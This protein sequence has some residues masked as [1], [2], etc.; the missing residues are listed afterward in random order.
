[1]FRNLAL[2]VLIVFTMSLT[3]CQSVL[4]RERPEQDD[5]VVQ[6]VPAPVEP[7]QP[8]VSP[9]LPE[10][11]QRPAVPKTHT[12]TIHEQT[13]QTPAHVDGRLVLGINETV[14]LPNLDLKMEAKLDTGAANS[15]ADARNIQFFERDGRKWVK[16]GL[17]RTSEGTVPVEM[18]LKGTIRI[19]RPGLPSLERPVVMMTL[20]IGDITQSVPVSLT[21]RSNYEFP[22]LI[23]RS[24][25]Q[26]L[27]VIDVNQQ[28]IAT[29]SVINT[30]KRQAVVPITQKSHTRAI[31]KPVSVD[32]LTTL[33]AVE[34]ITLPDSGT[35]LK[36]RIDTGA[37]TSSIDARDIKFFQKDG[38]QWV[39]F[40]L[41]NSAGKITTMKEPV[42]R[43][44]RIKR[45]NEE[46]ERRPVVT[47]KTRIGDILVPTQFT[48][49]SRENYE[50]PA[51]I[52]ARF[53]EKRALVDVATEYT[54]DKR[55]H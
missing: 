34:L 41:A 53:L 22:L 23:G 3:A 18:P 33:G 21:N 4:F 16:F 1:M 9:Q 55:Q 28:H 48:L 15:S 12:I 11:S 6:P 31:I 19:K 35:V 27:A 5:S 46:S 30:R 29:R 37:R 54:T 43:F 38:K 47:I 20:T 17:P 10:V 36:A 39:S 24:F 40:D 44:V 42:T 25:M 50:Y 32:G 26:D 14:T 51:L 49:R 2:S 13:I 8:V 45:H 52:G 7:E